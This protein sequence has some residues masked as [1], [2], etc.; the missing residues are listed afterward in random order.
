MTYIHRRFVEALLCIEV[1]K[2]LY[3][4]KTYYGMSDELNRLKACNNV[5]K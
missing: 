2:F 4:I 3:N 5:L 1:G